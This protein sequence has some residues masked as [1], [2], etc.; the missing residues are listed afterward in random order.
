MSSNNHD[1][2][3]GRIRRAAALA[4]LRMRLSRALSVT[5]AALTLGLAAAA[6]VLGAHK[7][8]PERVSE[9]HAYL[10]FS[11]IAALVV[12]AHGVAFLLRLPPNAGTL[13]LDKHHKLDGRLTNALEFLARPKAERSELM[14]AAIDDAC[15]V[16]T[17]KPKKST[18]STGRAA[19][20]IVPLETAAAV[21]PAIALVLLALLELPHAVPVPVV[22]QKT[23]DPLALSEDDINALRDAA[24]E[25]ERPNQ[26]AEVQQAIERYNRLIED[27]ANRRID[28]T[29]A[30][31]KM[32]SIER[33]LLDGAAADAKKLENELK[34]TAKQLE[35]SELAKDIA[36]AL[37]EQDLKK[38]EE[39]LKEL[40]K[41]LKEN[42]KP[43]KK[44]LERLRDALKKAAEQRK[45][46][47][48]AI[49]EKRKELEEQLL[50]KK[51]DVENATD[52]KKKEE[53]ERLLKKKE[54]EL[55][56]LNREGQEQQRANRELERLD[57]E[58]AE[59]AQN[60][61]KEMGVSQ[62]DL[63]KAAQDIN[64]AA[65]DINRMEREG[66]S[67]KDKERLKEQLEMAREILRQEQKSGKQ[68]RARQDNFSKRA[69]GKSGKGKSGKNGQQGEEQGDGPGEPGD[70]MEREQPGGQGEG[71]GEGEEGEGEGEKGKGKGKGQGEGEGEGAEGIEI[72]IG[73]GGNIPMPGPGQG[74][75]GQG[76]E[77]GEGA[78]KGDKGPGGKGSGGNP[79]GA[80]TDPDMGT[81]DVEAAAADTGSG[82]VAEQVIRSAADKGF[83]GSNY[84]KVYQDFNTRAEARIKNEG[85]PDGYRFYVQRY[86]QLIRPRE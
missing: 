59:A 40:A 60:L 84:K 18:L 46:A 20:I 69:R 48:E 73:P 78:G 27:L 68:R 67:Q 44:Q 8:A 29:D 16:V 11:G 54:R 80:S 81:V 64:Q 65:E 12:I 79:R 25:L 9:P 7:L 51:K 2:A 15:E 4:E 63:E 52:P 71:E 22:K 61:L 43:D 23:I 5:P 17:S 21:A 6:V 77:P 42:K 57:R 56:R 24:K 37:K 19:P 10:L 53:E 39:K 55:E 85:I 74:P 47:L 83:R 45:K 33:E 58:L 86:F 35:K 32:E 13:A 1:T 82:K 31:R 28:R 70:S 76:N 3:L 41:K 14:T 72:S 50:K 49:E 66:M 62:E 75:G 36:E 34:E 26:S 38:T 30:L